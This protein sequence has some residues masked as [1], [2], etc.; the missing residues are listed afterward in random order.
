MMENSFTENSVVGELEVM[1][2][3]FTENSVVG[4]LEL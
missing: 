3:S 4:G 2:N 1:E